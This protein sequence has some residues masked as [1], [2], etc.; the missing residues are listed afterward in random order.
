MTTDLFRPALAGAN[1]IAAAPL[2]V[3]AL[4]TAAAA[5]AIDWRTH[6]VPDALVGFTVVP[7]LLALVVDKEKV[8]PIQMAG[9]GLA[10]AALV[11]TAV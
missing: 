3:A 4:V 10:T 2:V 5:E 6:R 11:L 8:R 1:S 9:L 7:V